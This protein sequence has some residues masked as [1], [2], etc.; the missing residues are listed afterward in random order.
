M[1]VAIPVLMLAVFTSAAAHEESVD[2]KALVLNVEGAPIALSAG[3]SWLSV[4][5]QTTQP[6]SLYQLACARLSGSKLK[7]VHRFAEESFEIPP[8]AAV[9]SAGFHLPPDELL[10]CGRLQSKL[11]PIKAVMK[12]GHIWKWKP[13]AKVVQ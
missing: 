12:D 7:L 10:A 3:A 5:N 13:S 11:I 9:S 4:H 8:R 1:R 2:S 6:I